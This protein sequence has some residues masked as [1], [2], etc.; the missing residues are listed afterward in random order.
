MTGALRWPERAMDRQSEEFVRVQPRLREVI[1]GE[2]VD[3]FER[4]C[5][6]L[7]WTEALEQFY[8]LLRRLLAD[9]RGER[10]ALLP[11]S[12]STAAMLVPRIELAAPGLRQY[13]TNDRS[14]EGLALECVETRRPVTV[15]NVFEDDRRQSTGVDLLDQ[16]SQLYVPLFLRRP[17]DSA[18]CTGAHGEETVR[19][20]L[21]NRPR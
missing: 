4:G 19:T 21:L 8:D 10:I 2:G 11:Y 9:V 20:A 3:D 15:D 16:M 14:D 7:A 12:F 13:T 5:E 17:R 6:P 18:V 1:G